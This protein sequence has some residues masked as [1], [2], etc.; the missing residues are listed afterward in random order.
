MEIIRLTERNLEDFQKLFVE[1]FKELRGKQGWEPHDE[2]SY[3]MEAEHYF[4]RGDIVF[5]AFEDENAA[6]FI[7]VSSK[8]GSYWIEEIYVKPPFRGRGIGRALVKAAEE[9]VA[10]HDPAL[11]LFVLPQDRSAVAFWKKIGYDVVNTVELVK[12]LKEL[13]R[14]RGFHTIEILGEI[15]RIFKWRNED[16]S[17]EERE[18]MDLLKEFQRRRGGK[19]DLLRIFSSALKEWLENGS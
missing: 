12:D 7:R 3:R 1:F 16:L 17:E 10:K 18:F 6:G 19:R 9:E 8:D 5:L 14:D 2:A 11:Y 13:P 4:R 15:F